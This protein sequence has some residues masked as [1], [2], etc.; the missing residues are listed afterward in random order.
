M[1]A[2]DTGSANTYS[3]ATEDVDTDD[4]FMHRSDCE[5]YI[6]DIFSQYIE[7]GRRDI[8]RNP[9]TSLSTLLPSEVVIGLQ[10]WLS[11]L[12]ST[13]IWV[14]GEVVE[15]FGSGLSV[16][17]LRLCDASKEIGIP[18][19]SFICK[20]TYSFAR[21]SSSS[22]SGRQSRLDC[23]EASLIALLYSVTAQLIYLLPDDPFPANLVLEKSNFERLDGTMA[24]APTAL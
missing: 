22:R 21:S 15:Q 8:A 12:R 4:P 3:M 2:T 16:A 7:D 10:G 5:R 23:H 17:A 9:Q 6:R 14:E 24:S 19:I 20:Q 1:R 18:C 13:T 11:E